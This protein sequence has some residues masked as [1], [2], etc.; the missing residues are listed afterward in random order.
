M[1][2]NFRAQLADRGRVD[3]IYLQDGMRIAHRNSTDLDFI[4]SDTQF[5]GLS[6]RFSDERYARWLKSGCSHA[7]RNQ[8][9]AVNASGDSASGTL[10]RKLRATVVNARQVLR[11]TADAIAALLNFRAVGV[12][13]PVA[14]DAGCIAGWTN[15]HHL[16]KTGTRVR[17]TEFSNLFTVG[18]WQVIVTS[19]DHE[20]QISGAVH[21]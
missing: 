19:V 1:A 20:D 10:Q 3:V 18:R 4:V 12:E 6:C 13:Y 2:L 5:V 16:I 8:A 21:F 11:N 9:I 7:D 15:P 14:R 17:V